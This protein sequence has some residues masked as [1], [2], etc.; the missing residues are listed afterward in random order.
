MTKKGVFISYI[1]EEAALAGALKNHL[2]DAFPDKLNIFVSS[3]R[4]SIQAGAEWLQELKAALREAPIVIV[5][6]SEAS[7]GQPWVNFEAGGGWIRG[8]PVVPVCHSGLSPAELPVPL[9]MLNGIEAS[10]VAGLQKLHDVI[11]NML[12]EEPPESDPTHF[13]A[14][15]KNEF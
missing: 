7:V 10:D 6:C 14:R 9:K 3:D 13:V 12:D 15:F 1:S 4:K 8:A 2:N 5:M 11:A